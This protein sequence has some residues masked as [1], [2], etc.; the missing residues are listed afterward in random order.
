MA[1]YVKF[2][3]RV[4]RIEDVLDTINDKLD[5]NKTEAMENRRI[6][7]E[8]LIELKTVMTNHLKNHSGFIGNIKYV[9][10]TGVALIAVGIAIIF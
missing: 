3:K 2:D 9:V 5:K 4:E 8:L 1:D 6:D 7:R 10:T